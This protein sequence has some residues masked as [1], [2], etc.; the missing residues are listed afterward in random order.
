MYSLLFQHTDVDVPHLDD[1]AFS[2]M[3]GAFLT[4]DRPY[5]PLVDF[6]IYLYIYLF[7]V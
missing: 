2:Y 7:F 6:Y 3:R 4:I 1:E 5:P